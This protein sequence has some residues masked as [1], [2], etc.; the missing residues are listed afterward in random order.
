MSIAH[1]RLLHLSLALF[2]LSFMVACGPPL[3]TDPGVIALSRN[4]PNTRRPRR[5]SWR[6][7]R[8]RTR[9]NASPATDQTA[10][11]WV[12]LR[13]CSIRDRAISRQDDSD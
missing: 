4:L 1:T 8:P 7:A 2:A 5:N 3:D 6:S 13:I 10:T 12:R 9:K 11:D